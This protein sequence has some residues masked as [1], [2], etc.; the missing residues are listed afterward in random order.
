[1]LSQGGIDTV[2]TKFF[3]SKTRRG[4]FFALL[5]ALALF[6][7]AGEAAAFSAE[8]NLKNE[9]SGH[10]QI[11][12]RFD[13]IGAPESFTRNA[14]QSVEVVWPALRDLYPAGIVV[15]APPEAA[16]FDGIEPGPS[17]LLVKTRHPAF[18]FVFSLPQP[19]LL[20]IDL[21]NSPLGARWEPDGSAPSSLPPAAQSNVPPRAT[22]TQ[23]SPAAQPATPPV[24]PQ[25]AP[26]TGTPAAPA[27]QLPDFPVQP[28]AA[29][30]IETP[31]PTPVQEP[32][33]PPQPRPAGQA[34]PSAATPPLPPLQPAQPQATAQP[35][36]N[37]RPA[38]T[39]QPAQ[40]QAQI[41][42]AQPVQPAL[43]ATPVSPGGMTVP[44]ETAP[45][46]PLQLAPS[47]P[48]QNLPVQVPAT[49]PGSTAP[50]SP[51]GPGSA[52]PPQPGFA[53][54]AS[55]PASP[56]STD[57]PL[58]MPSLFDGL[59]GTAPEPLDDEEEQE[60]V[61]DP[62]D[63]P[64]RLPNVPTPPTYSGDEQSAL[65]PRRPVPGF[66]WNDLWP[67]GASL[68]HAA[69]A[70]AEGEEQGETILIEAPF[71][72][73]TG[74][75]RDGAPPAKGETPVYVR[76]PSDWEMRQQS[77]PPAG[78]RS[79]GAVTPPSGDGQPQPGAT[80]G[81]P[82]GAGGNALGD[83][84]AGPG[85]EAPAGEGVPQYSATRDA[86]KSRLP[87]GGSPGPVQTPQGEVLYVDEQGNPVAPPIDPREGAFE[88]ERLINTGYLQEGISLAEQLLR[89]SNLTPAQRETFLHRRADAIFTMYRNE[90]EKYFKEIM[91]SSSVAVNFNSRSP[92]NA[93]AWLRMGYV[94]L[95]SG[96][97]Y[98]AE[99]YFT[100]LR[101]QFPKD[102]TVPLSY[103]YMG[104]YQYEQGNLNDAALQFMYVV[105]EFPDSRYSR[106]AAL[107]L[108]RTFYRQ[109]LYDKAYEVIDYV[110]KR[111]PRYYLDYTPVLS[112]LGD[113]AYRARQSDR[114]R[115]AYWRY[116]NLNPDSTDADTILTRLGDIYFTQ[117]YRNAAVHVYEEAVRRFPDKN[118]G[119]IAMMRLAENSINDT[120]TLASMFRVF[121]QPYNLRPAEAY[122]KIIKD[123]P[124]NPLAQLAKLK[125]AMWNVFQKDFDAALRLC[126]EIVMANPNGPMAAEA[127]EVSRNAFAL[128]A[129]ES[130]TTKRY[131]RV[132]AA[133]ER[134]PLLHTQEEFLDPESRL[135]LAVS[136]W[137]GADPD[138]ALH[139]LEP[140]FLGNKI[141]EYSEMALLLALTVLGEYERWNEVETLLQRVE[142]WELTPE[143]KRQA[144]YAVALS[145]E[146][147]GKSP[148]AMPIWKELYEQNALP[149]EQQAYADYFLARQAEK[150]RDLETA[151]RI[152]QD[153]LARLKD[154]AA[155]N[156]Q[157]ADTEKIKTLLGSLM[158][159][160]Q[161]SGLIQNALDYGN[162]YLA[163]TS[164]G[165]D[166]YLSVM[167]N[168]AALHQ[169]RGS[170]GEWEKI[171]TDLSDNYPSTFYGRAAT[172]QL[173]SYRM[174]RDAS[175]F[176][177]SS[178]Y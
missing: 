33:R 173:N 68:A 138:A 57:A 169:R 160:A 76:V 53:P 99:A 29:P 36:P 3:S 31:R 69:E 122:R 150:D 32:E 42:P 171:L 130:V 129:A 176:A 30:V 115:E 47:Q 11:V 127:V 4:A 170:M 90:P 158:N 86:Q 18:G 77:P 98:E 5:L 24:A 60:P 126:N 25:T 101:Q 161:N 83:S 58:P 16:L 94:N 13:G 43:P 124:D 151:Y 148:E 50:G 70:P 27:G 174:N 128:L 93:G 72:F 39:P 73:R 123:F 116:Y 67:F 136:Q 6:G 81:P 153:A 15:A 166:D 46:A 156:P 111:W 28:E 149:P 103:Y 10:E 63:M 178:T 78:E 54:P 55:P 41:P 9:S 20:Q 74:I 59:P 167:Y 22:P 108:T 172:S 48:V 23:T 52:T 79:P 112:L 44:P 8:W 152:G 75:S 145:F 139:T 17:G 88:V 49:V 19:G 37:T 162:E 132:R 121:K 92:R 120:P 175:Q 110:E 26:A 2:A 114:A 34:D 164:R 141:P 102:E 155:L 1:M 157:Q 80:P 131:E 96:N 163:Y 84:S 89:Q 107:G 134:Y 97:A 146:N 14:A 142:L 65:E 159:I 109:G 87:G 168:M 62:L 64:S 71:I 56:G 51:T 100:L 117:K 12:L 7:R 82:S 61:W 133:W 119:I 106:D 177:P 125:L 144:D 21:F 137:E 40:P 85:G 95:K 165:S 154:L 147:Q 66:R 45:Q 104:D 118:G 35:A 143:T 38:Q 135:A 105:Q 113:T 91:D 140:F